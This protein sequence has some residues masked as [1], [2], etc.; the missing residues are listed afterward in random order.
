MNAAEPPH[1]QLSAV[2]DPSE[3]LHL[4]ADVVAVVRSNGDVLYV[5]D[6]V[7][8]LLG[9]PASSLVGAS[10]VDLIHPED[11]D[12]VLQRMD[13][14]FQG[15]VPTVNSMRLLHAAGDW[16]PIEL[17]AKSMLLPGE[18]G[19]AERVLMAN[20]R[21]VSERN[22]LL[23]RLRW[24][25][26]HDTL[27]G[28]LSLDGLHEQIETHSFGKCVAVMRLDA[29][30]FQRINEFYGHRFGDSVMARFGTRLAAVAGMDALVARLG[31]DDFVVLKACPQELPDELLN[32]DREGLEV[33]L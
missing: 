5:N 29:D 26:T 1:A 17:T 23:D 24:Q 11:R 6:A 19:E 33:A 15:A 22:E 10:I 9:Q 21:N 20:I 16:V 3:L 8:D 12:R 27:T 2:V 18:G 25:A 30:G 31:G 13:A 7:H 32:A 4:C 28:L 14:V